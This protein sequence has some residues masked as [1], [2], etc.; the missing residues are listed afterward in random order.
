MTLFAAALSGF[1]VLTLE[2]LGVHWLA[3]W[4]GTSALV[5]SN[6]IG[7]VL[8]A[9]ALGGWWGGR[10]AKRSEQPIRVAGASLLVSGLLVALAS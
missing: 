2:I 4:F 8:L 7:V 5:W 3:P 6:Q 1:A 9:M 10:V